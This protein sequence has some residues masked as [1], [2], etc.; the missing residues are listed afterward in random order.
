MSKFQLNATARIHA[1]VSLMCRSQIYHRKI[2][3]RVLYVYTKWARKRISAAGAQSAIARIF[4]MAYLLLR[5]C[6]VA[7]IF[8]VDRLRRRCH[9]NDIVALK[10]E[11]NAAATIRPET[12]CI[13]DV[14]YLY[15]YTS[16]VHIHIE[17]CVYIHC[18]V[19]R[20]LC[21]HYIYC[22]AQ[23]RW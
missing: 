10:A 16:D 5:I 2:R 21:T 7:C 3:R 8:I 14:M 20:C 17:S 6:T 22:C 12:N 13:F 9:H 23:T 15:I 4:K 19:Y 18:V 11:L 1:H